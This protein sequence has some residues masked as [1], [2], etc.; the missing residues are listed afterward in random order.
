MFVFFRHNQL[1]CEFHMSHL[2]AVSLLQMPI[3]KPGK[4]HSGQAYQILEIE[5]FEFKQQV[6]TS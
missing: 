3:S 2:A 5:Y 1:A 6:M 4:H